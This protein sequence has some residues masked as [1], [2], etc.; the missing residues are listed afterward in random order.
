MKPNEIRMTFLTLMSLFFLCT[1]SV[2]AEDQ[3]LHQTGI[4]SE[5]KNNCNILCF[6]GGVLL[7]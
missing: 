5:L 1:S 7:S 2:T 6:Y 3:V 4:I